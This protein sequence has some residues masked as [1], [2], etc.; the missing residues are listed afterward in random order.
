MSG[1]TLMTYF[2]KACRGHGGACLEP[3]GFFSADAG[4]GLVLAAL[5]LRGALRSKRGEESGLAV[6]H[7]T[8]GCGCS[9]CVHATFVMFFPV[10]CT[11]VLNVEVESADRAAIRVGVAD[12]K[13]GGGVSSS[14]LPERCLSHP[15][16]ILRVEISIWSP[17]SAIVKRL[18]RKETKTS[19]T[20]R[21]MGRGKH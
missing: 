21:G 18:R 15:P 14:P 10:A 3:R 1:R 8:D 16:G 2:T 12:L 17:L 19:A 20:E 13:P 9:L 11:V 4:L 7:R 6:H 5:I